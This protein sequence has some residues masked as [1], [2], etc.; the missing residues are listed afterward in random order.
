MIKFLSL[1][2]SCII[3]N[4]CS[5]KE[6]IIVF[7]N[8]QFENELISFIKEQEK[9]NPERSTINLRIED[10]EDIFVDVDDIKNQSLYLTF[11]YY[12]PENCEGF[13][14][15][16][17]Y[18]GKKIFLFDNSEKIK[19][20]DLLMIKNEN[21]TCD[22]I[23]LRTHIDAQPIRRYYFDKNMKLVEIESNGT[24]RIVE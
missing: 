17:N 12:S 24:L 3:L 21:D 13:Y 9:N 10:E 22:E 8:Q 18:M 7:K 4:S 1:L 23:K 2:I 15:S 14:K 19:F 16:F 5:K 20:K 11:Y 6:E